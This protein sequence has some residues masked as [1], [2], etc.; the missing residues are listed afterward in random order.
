MKMF[1]KMVVMFAGIGM[2]LGGLG[3][4]AAVAT[5]TGLRGW[6]SKEISRAEGALRVMAIVAHPDDADFR[7]GCLAVKLARLGARV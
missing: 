2:A 5:K 1:C 4:E 6:N 7:M 3:I